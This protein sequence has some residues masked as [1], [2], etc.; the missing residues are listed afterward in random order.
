MKRELRPHQACAIEKLRQSLGSGKRRPV[1]QAP[2]GFGKTLLAAAVVEGALAKQ[3]RVIFTVPALS[4]VDQTVRAFWDQGISDVGVIQGTHPMT[5]WGRPVQVAS[6]QTLQRRGIPEVDVVIIDEC[7]RLFDFYGR[8]MKDP[9]WQNRP[10]IGLSA[11]P[12]TLGLGQYFDDLIIATTT[13][14]LISEGYLSPFRVF[15]PSHPD[16]T[17]VRTVEGD[18]YEPDLSSVMNEAPL[19]ADVV[20]TWRRRAENR[21]TFCFA[22]DRTHAKHLQAKFAEA[23]VSTGYIDAYT[24]AKERDE[25]K[26]QF[27]DG[28]I[29]VVCNVGCLTTGVDWDVR[30]I[31]LARPTKSEIL[32]VQ[33]IGRGLRI[34]EGKEDCLILDHSDTHL[35]LGFV[36]DIHH[37]VLD[38][39]RARAKPKASDRIRLPKECPQ[40]AF[41]KPPR[42]S[43]C[44]ACGFKAEAVDNT[45]VA[46]GE[47]VEITGG[48]KRGKAASKDERAA[49]Y[50]QLMGYAQARGYSSGWAAHKFREKFDV[51]PNDYRSLPAMEPT[52]KM[53]SWIKSR[54]IAWAKSKQRHAQQNTA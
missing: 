12:W 54:Q 8:W 42:M 29:R 43:E 34:A 35:R 41:L 19:V 31:V 2:T 38:D 33:I 6:V 44:P 4:L 11:T 48:K 22:V 52:P 14:D 5:D 26:R 15:A 21:S 47:L 17:R 51:W 25:I 37:D 7:H 49:F 18:Y 9:A 50:A 30:C 16:L 40:C 1:L 28:D 39:G 27:H 10:F 20:D 13:Q 45:Q 32:F 46:E 3:K 24:L 53:R 36:T 23:G